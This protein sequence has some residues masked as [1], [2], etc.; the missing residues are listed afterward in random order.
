MKQQSSESESDGSR[1]FIRVVLY[2]SRPLL[3]FQYGVCIHSLVF[4]SFFFQKKTTFVTYMLW[5][6]ISGPTPKVWQ[7]VTPNAFG[8]ILYCINAYEPSLLLCLSYASLAFT[9]SSIRYYFHW[10]WRCAVSFSVH[11]IFFSSPF[12]PLGLVWK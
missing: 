1:L 3:V 8:L 6:I 4:S 2:T 9:G 10:N 11:K 7:D 12:Q 5:H